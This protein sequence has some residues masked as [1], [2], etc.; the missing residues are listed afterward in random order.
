MKKSLLRFILIICTMPWI[1]AVIWGQTTHPAALALHQE[2]L[3]LDTHCDTPLRMLDTTWDIGAYHKPG[4]RSAGKIDLPRMRNGNLDAEF[5]AVYV[6]QRPLTEENYR[7]ARESA[8]QLFRLIDKMLQTYP[9]VIRLATTPED[10]YA[11]EKQGLLSAYIGVENGF[12]LGHDLN[13]LAELHQRGVRYITLCHTRNNDICDSSTDDSGP[14]YHGLS[15]FGRTLI[16]EMNR[17]GILVDVSHASDETFYQALEVSKAPIFASHSCVRAL[18]NNPR[19][20]SDEM[21]QALATHDG[22]LQMCILSDYVKEMPVNPQ[23]EAAIAALREKYGTWETIQDDSA[24]RL[25]R[26]AYNELDI[27]YP[28]HLATVADVVDHIDHV[29]RL[30]G[31]NHIGIGTDFDGGGGVSGCNDVS[32][33][34]NITAELLKR[35]YRREDIEKIWGGNFMRIF[36]RSLEISKE[37]NQ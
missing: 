18:C 27:Q 7:K 30:V 37:L 25:L 3:T 24:R 4:V 35:N 12:A 29:V 16:A 34:S 28:R 20:L 21:I 11:N 1:P 32:Q 33:M 15:D 13:R 14:L 10:A 6:A 36:R 31:I 5:F 22:V 23:R 9:D 2:I 17:L 26:Q 8:D 19:N